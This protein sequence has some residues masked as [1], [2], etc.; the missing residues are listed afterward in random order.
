MKKV[1][2]LGAS[3]NKRRFSHTCVKTLM[4]QGYEVI[5]IGAREGEI[6][7]KKIIQGKPSVEDLHTVTLYLSPRNQ[8]EYYD[9]VFGQNPQRIIFNPGAEN[10]NFADLAKKN[11][12]EVVEDCTLVML[13]SGNF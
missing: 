4:H 3:P 9:Y 13:N 12:I 5:P 11:G 10:P 2:V 6:N 8:E 1:M 7:G